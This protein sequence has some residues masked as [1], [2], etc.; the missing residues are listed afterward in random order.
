MLGV[1]AFAAIVAASFFLSRRAPSAPAPGPNANGSLPA[2]PAPTPTPT[3][4]PPAPPRA[5]AGELVDFGIAPKSELESNV[6]SPTPMS[7]PVGT[8]VTTEQVQRMLAENRAIPVDV[9]AGAHPQTLPGALYMPAGGMPGAFD[10]NYQAEFTQQLTQALGGD[11]ARPLI[12]F[13]Q[14]ASCW[15]SYNAALRA[16][17]AGATQIYWYRGGLAA[18]QEAGLPMMPLPAPFGGT[19]KSY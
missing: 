13:C 4:A 8:R 16:G 11:P 6:G 3:P 17:A 1:L 2:L 5:Y 19:G 10:D 14:G 9:L 15:E 18:W 7:I 12:F